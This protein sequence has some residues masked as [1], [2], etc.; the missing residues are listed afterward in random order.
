[1]PLAQL[2]Y[3]IIIVW[4]EHCL[5]KRV[6][7]DFK[8]HQAM[9]TPSFC[10]EITNMLDWGCGAHNRGHQTTNWKHKCS[11]QKNMTKTYRGKI[12]LFIDY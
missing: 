1:M 10:K 9:H 7:K 2:H 8:R 3:H 11:C 6:S 12:K 5:E 4:Q